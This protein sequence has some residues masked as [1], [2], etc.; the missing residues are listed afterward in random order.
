MRRFLIIVAWASF[1]GSGFDGAITVFLGWLIATGE[2]SMSLTVDAHL[3]DHLPFLYWVRALAEAI[4]PQSFVDWV[5]A[6]PALVYFPRA[7][8][9]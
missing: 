6:L 1:L 8:C 2:A 9:H 3:R 4:L 7:C 5:F